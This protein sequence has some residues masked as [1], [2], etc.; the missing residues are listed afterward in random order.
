MQRLT[1]MTL[2][3]VLIGLCGFVY[4]QASAQTPQACSQREIDVYFE[5]DSTAFNEFSK[6][7]VERVAQE[8]R[9][10]GSRQVVVKAASGAERAQAVSSAFNKLGVKVILVPTSVSAP[11]SDSVADRAVTIRVASMPN[12][13]G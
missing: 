4:D 6:Q 1:A 2:G 5:R 9:N 8:A 12:A 7:L 10:C 3:A 13:V 11:Q